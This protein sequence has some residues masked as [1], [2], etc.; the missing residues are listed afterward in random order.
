M[1]IK[2]RHLFTSESVTEGHPDK[3]C[4]QIS[5]AVLDAFL[6]VDPFARVACEVSVATGLV[7][8]IGEISSRA[9]YVDIPA[10]VRSKIKEIGYTRAKYGFDYNTCAV[11]TSLNEQSADIAQGVNAAIETRDGKDI[12][13]ENE[14]IGAGDQGLMFGYATNE[15]PELMPLPIAL[16]HRIAR[17]LSEVRKDGTLAYLRPD[18]KTQVTIEYVDGQPQRVDAIVV[19]TQHAEE[20]TLEQIQRDIREHVIAPV[21]PEKWLDDATKY[22]INPT[23]RFV[24]GGPQGDAGLTGRKIIVDTYGGYARHGGGAFSGKDPTKVDRSAAYAARYVAKNLVAAGLADKCEIQLAYAIG[25]AN[26]VSIS[27]DTYGTGKVAEETLVELIR[28]N[29]DLRPAGIIKM[30]DLRRPIYSRTAA[31]GHFG[32]TDIDLP[33][34][35]VDKAEQLKAGAGV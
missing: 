3:I 2:G 31:Y 6:E 10:I 26:P 1:A 11:L 9:D 25:V 24:I 12:R 7:L 32:R 35:R 4:D 5:D 14:D 13:Q 33:W 15:T 30:L 23:G 29:F 18:G 27:V 28:G 22:Y 21:V 34:E 20:V 17:R 8:V 16:S 19:S